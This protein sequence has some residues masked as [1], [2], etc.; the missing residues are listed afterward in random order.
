MKRIAFSFLIF[1][2]TP[3]VILAQDVYLSL[4]SAGARKADLALCFFGSEPE[5][6]LDKIE[7]HKKILINDLEFSGLFEII[8]ISKFSGDFQEAFK[9]NTSMPYDKW[10]LVG[11]QAL[12][13]AQIT[14]TENEISL[15]GRIYDAKLG[16]FI[17]GK[18]YTSVH[19]RDREL[20]HRFA[21]EVVFRFSGEPGVAS[22]K[23]AFISDIT[24]NKEL[25]IMDYDGENVIRLTSYNSITLIPAWSPDGKNIAF[26]SYYDKTPKIVMLNLATRATKILAG[27]PGLNASPAF[28]PDGKYIACSLSKDGN[29]EIYLIEVETLKLTRLTYDNNI[30]TAPTFSPNGREIAFTSDRS[31]R[32]QIYVIDVEGTS[33]RRLTYDEYNNDSPDWSPK[34]NL[35]VFTSQRGNNTDICLMDSFGGNV[36]V[37]TSQSGNNEHP[38]WA[39]DGYHIVF[40]SNRSGKS[41]IY[42]MNIDGS[43]QRRIT[44]NKGN[45]INPSWGPR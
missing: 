21:D 2:L 16:R 37:L 8:D 38:T 35:I 45:N 13:V 7:A 39:P 27:Y 44:F 1:L 17:Y 28:S 33:L 42:V 9:N 40:S 5:K 14:Y 18:K 19:S 23:I 15:D 34:G 36:R 10:Y 25:Y 31:G 20:I 24:G 41:H 26:T 6:Y 3:A 4:S 22:T 43:G 11:I 30:D 29:S 12:V 32:P